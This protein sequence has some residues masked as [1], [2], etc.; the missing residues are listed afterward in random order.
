MLKK[1]ILEQLK[2]F[3]NTTDYMAFTESESERLKDYSTPDHKEIHRELFKVLATISQLKSEVT[4]IKKYFP[5]DKSPEI[6][7]AL[8]DITSALDNGSHHI[9]DI[10]NNLNIDK[11]TKEKAQ[12]SLIDS[13]EDKIKKINKAYDAI[14]WHTG[15]EN[16]IISDLVDKSGVD[17]KFIQDW[18]LSE[19][20]KGRAFITVGEPTSLSPHQRSAFVVINDRNHYLVRLPR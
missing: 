18:L 12:T 20:R 10:S 16:V 7:E 11:E 6:A 19:G 15:F 8:D 17:L 4:A 9:L 3:I 13:T 14:V 1:D 2:S 5:E